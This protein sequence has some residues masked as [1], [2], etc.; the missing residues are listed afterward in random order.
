MFNAVYLQMHTR[1][2]PLHGLLGAFMCRDNKN[3]AFGFS[4]DPFT[5]ATH[6]KLVHRTSTMRTYN[7]HLYIE[8]RGFL[9]N[10]FYRCA[11]YKKGCSI[12]ACIAQSSCNLL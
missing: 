5:D 10:C 11:L 4:N 1:C 7:N 2:D 6:K 8:F 12:E 9:Q 3:L